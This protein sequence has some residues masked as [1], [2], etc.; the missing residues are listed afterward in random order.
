MLCGPSSISKKG[1]L[2]VERNH[3]SPNE[4][5]T[6]TCSLYAIPW[7]R[8]WFP[9][10]SNWCIVIIWIRMK[11]GRTKTTS[12]RAITEVEYLVGQFDSGAPLLTAES[13]VR[14]QTPANATFETCSL[15]RNS[16]NALPRFSTPIAVRFHPGSDCHTSY[17]FTVHMLFVWIEF[18]PLAASAMS[19]RAFALLM[20]ALPIDS[21]KELNRSVF[22]GHSCFKYFQVT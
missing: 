20:T 22:C 13:P 18:G 15:H 12:V 14:C 9:E 21:R 10:I 16:L 1:N 17:S 4:P 8:G 6:K 19:A 11:E 3:P 2:Q 7:H 5:Q